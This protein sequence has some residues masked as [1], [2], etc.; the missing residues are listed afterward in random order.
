MIYQCDLCEFWGTAAQL[1][2]CGALDLCPQCA[3]EWETE[4][5]DREYERDEEED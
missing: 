5:L 2:P 1:Q 3:A 4:K